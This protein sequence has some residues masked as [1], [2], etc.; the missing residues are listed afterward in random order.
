VLVARRAAQQAQ[1]VVVR[2]TRLLAVEKVYCDIL[3]LQQ[4]LA[5]LAGRR[6]VLAAARRRSFK[7]RVEPATF[8]I[9]PDDVQAVKVSVLL[10]CTTKQRV[11]IKA[12]RASFVA[13][14]PTAKLESELSTLL[15]FR[16]DPP[17]RAHRRGLVRR[18]V[19]RLVAQAG[20]WR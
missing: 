18:G 20:R 17:D 14:L 4:R 6:A 19:C 13:D 2:G 10:T 8:R 12:A 7:R 11:T 1:Q 3:Q 15:D 16:R 5:R 9:A